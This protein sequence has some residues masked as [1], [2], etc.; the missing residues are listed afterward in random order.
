M[1]LLITTPY[2]STV[3]GTEIETLTTAQ[4]L[5]NLEKFEKIEIFS[6]NKI[7]LVNLVGLA[8][9]PNIKFKTYPIFFNHIIF[10]NINIVFRRIFN[11]KSSFLENTYWFLKSLSRIDNIYILTS[12]TQQYYIPIIN[13]F[14]PKI[15]LIKY[16][17]VYEEEMEEWK[18]RYLKSFKWNIVTSKRHQL[19]FNNIL[20]SNNVVVQDLIIANEQSLLECQSNRK[21]TF[22]LLCR[23]SK[24]K[25]IEHAIT[26]IHKLNLSGLNASLIIQ[27]DGDE[28]YFYQ[29][30]ELI[31]NYRLNEYVTLIKENIPPAFTH[32]FYRNISFFL[33]T[34]KFET[35]PLTGLEAMA[36]G[37]P[38]LSY[39]VGAMKERIG[40]QSYLIVSDFDNMLNTAERLMKLSEVEYKNLSDSLRRIYISKCSNTLKVKS[41]GNLFFQD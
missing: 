2:L 8:S 5:A 23:F 17:L 15:C 26:L 13:N 21:Y 27:G 1:K 38:V 28:S 7:D 37:V 22:G 10:K 34:S 4:E 14:N 30:K 31:K 19:F 3:G 24:E 16:T 20:E 35:G 32:L 9:N 33:I 39:N 29:L 6:P 11:L 36:S 18:K 40:E 41:L 25:R 12:N